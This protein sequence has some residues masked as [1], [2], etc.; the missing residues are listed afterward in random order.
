MKQRNLEDALNRLDEYL[1]TLDDDAFFAKLDTSLEKLKCKSIRQI[2]LNSSY[3]V[4]HR[5]VTSMFDANSHD[6]SKVSHP[7][8]DVSFSLS[9]NITTVRYSLS[10]E[11][12]R[13][14]SNQTHAA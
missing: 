4:N 14:L 3:C 13:V 5:S 6:I 9:P 11:S 1:A 12:N 2:N 8:V 7:E 10:P